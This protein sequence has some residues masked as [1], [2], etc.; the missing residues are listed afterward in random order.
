M[1]RKTIS[2]GKRTRGSV[3][4]GTSSAASAIF[5]G[6]LLKW[7]SKRKTIVSTTSKIEQSSEQQ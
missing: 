7:M 5:F 4:S 1:I 2:E 6:R 3:V